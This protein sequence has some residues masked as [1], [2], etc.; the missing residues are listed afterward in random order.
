M[1]GKTTTRKR[2]TTPAASSDRARVRLPR[3]RIG[4]V[5]SRFIARTVST[6]SSVTTRLFA[7]LSGSSSVDE[8]TTLGTSSRAV[9]SS[10]AAIPDMRR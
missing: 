7:Q 5:P 3:V 10:D 8:N 1:T 6:G 4:V 2:S 9:K